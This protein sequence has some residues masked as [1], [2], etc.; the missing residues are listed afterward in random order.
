MN[1]AEGWPS[2]APDTLRAIA[3]ATMDQLS[4]WFQSSAD[5]G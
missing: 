5:Q 3:D 4:S 1:G 2:V